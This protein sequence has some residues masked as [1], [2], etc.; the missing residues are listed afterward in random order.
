MHAEI[1]GVD[2]LILPSEYTTWC[3]STQNDKAALVLRD[4]LAIL[5]PPA[6]AAYVLNPHLPA[7]QQALTPT[8]TL[9]GTTWTLDDHPLATPLIPLQRGTHTLTAHH[10]ERTASTS[11]TVE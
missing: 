5:Y 8:S 9:P 11:F 10:A 2:L 4:D 6:N 7:A 3:A 1:D